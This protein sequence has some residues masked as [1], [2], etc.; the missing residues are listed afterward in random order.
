MRIPNELF[1]EFFWEDGKTHPTTVSIT[2]SNTLFKTHDIDSYIIPEIQK[3]VVK[4]T[5]WKKIGNFFKKSG[6]YIGI[7]GAGALVGGLLI[8]GS[9]G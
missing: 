1:L 3:D 4:P 8:A 6:K 9:G 7:F 5:G 2:N